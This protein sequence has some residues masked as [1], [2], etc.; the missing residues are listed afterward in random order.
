VKWN[1]PL[2]GMEN[3]RWFLSFHCFDSYVKVSFFEGARL[4]PPPPETSKYP[5]IRYAHIR[6]G[7]VLGEQFTDWVRQA[8]KLPGVKM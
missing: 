3:D 7:D 2:Y 6:E 1:T 5:A 4:D 8:S